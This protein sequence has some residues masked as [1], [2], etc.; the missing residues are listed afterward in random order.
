MNAS[1]LWRFSAVFV[2]PAATLAKVGLILAGLAVILMGSTRVALADGTIYLPMA[3]SMEKTAAPTCIQL[4]Q[5][6]EQTGQGP[7]PCN[8]PTP[9]PV[10]TECTP[11]PV[12]TAVPTRQ[13]GQEI[14]GRLRR[15][16]VCEG[17]ELVDCYG[18]QLITLSCIQCDPYEGQWVRIVTNGL[19]VICDPGGSSHEVA[20]VIP[21]ADPCQQATPTPTTNQRAT[22]ILVIANQPCWKWEVWTCDGILV[23]RVQDPGN[24]FGPGRGIIEGDY[25]SFAGRASECAGTTVLIAES[26]IAQI[27]PIP[28]FIKQGRLI[29]QDTYCNGQIAARYMLLPCGATDAPLILSCSDSQCGAYVDQ[30]AII[31]WSRHS[32]CLVGARPFPVIFVDT[33]TAAPDPCPI[34]ATPVPTP[35]LCDSSSWDFRSIGPPEDCR[36]FDSHGMPVRFNIEKRILLPS[37]VTTFVENSFYLLGGYTGQVVGEGDRT[38]YCAGTTEATIRQDMIDHMARRRLDPQFRADRKTIGEVTVAEARAWSILRD[39]CVGVTV[40]EKMQERDRVDPHEGTWVRWGDATTFGVVEHWRNWGTD[41]TLYVLLLEPGQI[42]D[43]HGGG[44]WFSTQCEIEARNEFARVS[45]I[46][47]VITIG[48]LARSGLARCV[49]GSRDCPRLLSA[50]KEPATQ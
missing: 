14:N 47:P 13:F 19:L 42:Y 49:L 9:T 24:Y 16:N 35:V 2:S 43:I 37:G 5:L 15:A 10:P 41:R 44:T 25:I 11:T 1:R 3:S 30:W 21:L 7:C 36:F 46:R 20:L 22:G 4:Q 12:P 48:D 45:K 26:P 6:Y 33:I 17:W 34:Q 28:C 8:C 31:T 23:A 27:D 32:D 39:D 18:N 29:R 38:I 40:C 50:G